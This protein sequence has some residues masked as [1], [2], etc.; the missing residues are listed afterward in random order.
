MFES[1]NAWETTGNSSAVTARK[2]SKVGPT[3]QFAIYLEKLARE[4]LLKACTDFPTDAKMQLIKKV[5]PSLL[6]EEETQMKE[7]GPPAKTG[8]VNKHAAQTKL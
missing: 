1:L 4:L 2:Y 5:Y 6:V 7:P 8:H 3:T